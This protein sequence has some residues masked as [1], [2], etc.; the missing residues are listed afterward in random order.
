MSIGEDRATHGTLGDGTKAETEM[1]HNADT[2]II[3]RPISMHF[4]IDEFIV[5]VIVVSLLFDTWFVPL[6]QI[7]LDPIVSTKKNRIEMGLCSALFIS[8]SLAFVVGNRF[9][10]SRKRMSIEDVMMVLERSMII[11]I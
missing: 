11:T 5:L 10:K 7:R 1:A 4:F 2:T 3:R 8:F 6:D 9:H